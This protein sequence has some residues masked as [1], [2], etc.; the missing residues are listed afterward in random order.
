MDIFSGL[1]PKQQ[2]AVASLEGPL[3]IMAGAGSGKTKVLTCRIANLLAHG[4][5]PFSI[6]AITF[7]NKAAAEMRERV[8]R[9][10]GPAAKS[11]WLSTFHSFCARFL[12][13]EIEATEMYKKNFVIYDAADSKAVIKA[14]LKELNLDEKQYAPNSVQAAISNAKNM[15]MGPRAFARDAGSF[16]QKKTAEVYELYAKKLRAN[17]ALDFDDLLM[18]SVAILEEHEDIRTRYQQRFRYI[19]VDEYQDTN[20]AQYELTKILAAKYRNLCVVG[21]ADQSIYGWRGADIRNIMDFEKDYP[22]ART[23]KLEQ[24]YRSTKNILAAANAVIAHNE[25]RKP[26]KLWTENPVGEKITS[27]LAND[28]RDEANFIATTILKQR[29]IFN[30]AYGDIAILYRTNAQSRVLEEGFMRE[31][32]PYTMVGGLKFYDRKEIKDAIA[33]LRVIFNPMDSVSLM[34]IINVPKRGLGET[35]IARLNAYAVENDM[36]LFDVISSPEILGGIS[37]ITARVKK[38]LEVFSTMIFDLLGV[39]DQLPLADFIER[40]LKDSGYLAELEREPKPENESRVENLKEF[41]GVAKDFEKSGE[42]PNVEN[43]LSHISLISDIDSADIELDRVTLMTLHSAKG[44]EFPIVFMAGMEE[45][46]F[47]HART[48]MEPD[49]MEEERRTCYVGITRAQRKLYMT[50]ARSRMI[51]GRTTTY[52]PSRFLAEIPDEYI[53]RLVV[54]ANSYGFANSSVVDQ[55]GY[56]GGASFRPSARQM[57]SGASGAGQGHPQSALQALNAMRER[58]AAGMPIVQADGVIRPDMDVVWKPG[59]KARH[60]KW[61]VGTVVSV[62]GRGEEVELKIAFP[63]QGVKGLMQKYA[64]I[65]KVDE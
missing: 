42:I 19:L 5:Q 30:A 43:F 24:N 16:F 13:Y 4:V 39:M 51:Y 15:L 23:V 29:T 21:D 35:T 49:E 3:L 28:E 36:T 7:T 34:R 58:T 14:C 32:I 44:L 25:N 1:N 27:Y 53:E 48:L 60:G 38:P 41:I 12:R 6:L 57:G 64:P 47:P 55:R 8:D 50:Y 33:Y 20:G 26:K 9:L 10:I 45:G 65:A 31:G 56:G 52:L 2:E 54:R 17:N 11:V 37:G 63:G 61:G 40:M 46:L 18:V 62:K 59:D 22:E